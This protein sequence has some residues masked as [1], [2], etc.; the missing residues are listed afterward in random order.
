MI[1][2]LDYKTDILENGF[3]NAIINQKDD[4]EGK[5]ICTIIR[6]KTTNHKNKAVLYIHGFNDYFFQTEMADFFNKNEFHFY[7]L[8]LRKYGRSHLPNQKLNNV[9]NLNE[10]FED[11]SKALEIIKE[12]GSEK[13]ILSGHSTGGLI[14]SI[15]AQEKSNENSFNTLFLNSPFFDFNMNSIVKSI[16][17]PIISAIGSLFPNI[18]ANGGFSE[19]YGKSLHKEAYGEWNYNLAWKPHV[20]PLVNLGFIKAIYLAQKK[21]KKRLKISVP[22][23][24]M[25]SNNSIYEKKWS[26]KMFTGDAILNVNDIHRESK[27]ILGNTLIKVISNGQHDLILSPKPV[28]EQVYKELF[29]WIEKAI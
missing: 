6:K 21:V 29:E 14:A 24:V 10:Y 25:H 7:A 15:Y 1:Y 4:Y 20:P 16:G 19:L 11:I 12:E 13:I 26:D 22:I 28:R 17:I 5:V 9:R 23:L 3:E 2:S 18:I 27:K 8:D